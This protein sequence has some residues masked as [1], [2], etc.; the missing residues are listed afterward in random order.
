[1]DSIFKS[2]DSNRLGF[3]YDSGH[4]NCNHPDADCLSRYG[5]RLFAVHLDDNYGDDDTHLLPYDGTVNW[6]NVKKGLANSRKI[7]YMTLEVDFN[8]KHEKSKIYKNLSADKFL[9]LAYKKAQKFLG[10]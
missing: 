2:I 1:L 4:E 7:N 8:P 10:E 3:C 6:S 5:H 9:T